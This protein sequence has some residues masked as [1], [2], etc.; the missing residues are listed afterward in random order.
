MKGVNYASITRN[1]HIPQYCGSCW[2][3]GS[4]SAMAGGWSGLQDKPKA[5]PVPWLH[6]W[7]HFTSPPPPQAAS[8]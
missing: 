2:A 6:A 8:R 1:Q 3:H 4:T 5:E 7:L